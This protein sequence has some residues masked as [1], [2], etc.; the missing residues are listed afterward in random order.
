MEVGLVGVTSMCTVCVFPGLSLW[1][2]ATT[3]KWNEV[4]KSRSAA[5]LSGSKKVAAPPTAGGSHSTAMTTLL[6]SAVVPGCVC[7]VL[8]GKA[9]VDRVDVVQCG[10]DELM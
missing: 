8:L 1:S 7:E 3:A 4:K 5:Q 2:Q 6:R 9:C 10:V